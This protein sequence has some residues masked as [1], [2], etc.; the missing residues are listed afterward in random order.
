MRCKRSK[1]MDTQTLVTHNTNKSSLNL[2]HQTN[3]YFPFFFFLSCLVCQV[4]R[5]AQLVFA[6]VNISVPFS[7]TKKK[8]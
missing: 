5:L 2:K 4:S 6:V 8:R 7:F 1:G 3:Y